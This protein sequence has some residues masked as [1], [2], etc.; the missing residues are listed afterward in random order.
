MAFSGKPMSPP[1]PLLYVRRWED[2]QLF[3]NSVKLS[4]SPLYLYRDYKLQYP[5]PSGSTHMKLPGRPPDKNCKTLRKLAKP[6]TAKVWWLS[7]NY[8]HVTD[9]SGNVNTKSSVTDHLWRFVNI[10]PCVLL[11]ATKDATSL[12][13][14][15]KQC[16]IG[17][18]WGTG[19]WSTDFRDFEMQPNL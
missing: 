15:G 1:L 11:H 7:I 10:N 8:R 4:S 6:R 16:A 17:A 5:S 14:A 19:D 12:H 2:H 13:R 9:R 3:Y 18:M